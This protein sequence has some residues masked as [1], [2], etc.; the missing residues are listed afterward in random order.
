MC[1]L[2]SSK[3]SNLPCVRI[4]SMSETLQHTTFYVENSNQENCTPS[5][6][7]M[8]RSSKIRGVGFSELKLLYPLHIQCTKKKKSWE[9][10]NRQVRLRNVCYNV[11]N[12]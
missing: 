1:E 8:K 7:N 5:E 6:Q 2:K 9:Q 12:Q 3:E 4:S 10:W 11:Q